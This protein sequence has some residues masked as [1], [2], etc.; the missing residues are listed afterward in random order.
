MLNRP[1]IPITLVCLLALALAI[2]GCTNDPL[3]PE[4]PVNASIN[5]FPM[6]EGD[7]YYEFWF[8]YPKAGTSPKDKHFDDGDRDYVAAGSFRVDAS[9]HAVDLQGNP[10]QFIIPEGFQADLI[11]DAL[12][13]LEHENQGLGTPQ[14]R[15]LAGLFT[16][17]GSQL[18]A[19]LKPNDS[20]AFGPKLAVDSSSWCLLQAPTSDDPPDSVSGIWFVTFR[21]RSGG[22]I[23]TLSGLALAPQPLNPDNPGW[24][25]QTWLVRNAGSGSP[26]YV[27]MGRFRTLTGPDADGPGPGAG[28]HPERAYGRPGEDFTGALRRVLNDGTYGIVVSVE[29]DSVELSHPFIPLYS[30]NTIAAGAAARTLILLPIATTSPSMEITIER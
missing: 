25:Y 29:P 27:K 8:S 22:G 6:L 21:N 5:N 16:G 12:V 13:T 1:L 9:G 4:K 19:V 18:D 23:D 20:A 24:T 10:A 11:S 15:V 14:R 2:T 7:L 3:A 28:S 26:E 30:L 17:T